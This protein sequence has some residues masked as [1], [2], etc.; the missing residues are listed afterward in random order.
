MVST[1]ADVEHDFAGLRFSATDWPIVVIEFPERRV[2]DPA[3]RELLARLESLM[4]DAAKRRERFFVVIDVTSMREIAPASQRRYAGEWN[5]R[6]DP[7]A[8]AVTLGGAA[9]TPSSILRGIMTAVFWIH[10]P[11]RTMYTAATRREAMIKGVQVL[12][13]ERIPLPPRLATYRL[14]RPR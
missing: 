12:E 9:V 1:M 8:T 11:K 7:L 10:P 4:N 5:R 14:D 3:L 6:L 2:P 13:R